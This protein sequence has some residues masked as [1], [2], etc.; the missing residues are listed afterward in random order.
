MRRGKNRSQ[1]GGSY[2]IGQRRK[3]NLSADFRIQKIGI[4]AYL[5]QG[6]HT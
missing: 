3:N 1:S 2:I 5:A 6:W 4:C